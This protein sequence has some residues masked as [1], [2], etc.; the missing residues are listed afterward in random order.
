MSGVRDL[1]APYHDK[2][3]AA[4]LSHLSTARCGEA[5]NPPAQ[6]MFCKHPFLVSHLTEG[7]RN[8]QKTKLMWFL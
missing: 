2:S 1:P 3:P 5:T 7:H 8:T 4:S 6:A